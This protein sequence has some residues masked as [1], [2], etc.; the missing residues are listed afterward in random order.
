MDYIDF[1]AELV[2]TLSSMAR[3]GEEVFLRQITKNNGIVYDGITLRVPGSNI[4]P[5]LY[6]GKMK[7]DFDEGKGSISDLAAAAARICRSKAVSSRQ[8][9]NE[10]MDYENFKDRVCFRLVNRERN[11]VR[12]QDMPHHDILD[13]SMIYFFHTESICDLSGTVLIHNFDL[14]R[15]DVKE[16]ELYQDALRNTPILEPPE[17]YRL[18]EYDGFEIRIFTNKKGLYGAG[19]MLYEGV[20]ADYAGKWEQDLF[21]LPSSIHEVLVLPDLG[22]H[23]PEYL[24]SMVT[25][26]NA[27]VVADEEVLSDE[28]YVWRYGSGEIEMA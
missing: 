10:L 11:R 3:E 4:S 14:S 26:V 23:T 7:Q 9:E 12:L 5:T 22:E 17:T 16:E 27:V 20:L 21:V 24:K 2:E 1:R 28:V 19:V 13:L 8:I 6:I 18:V 15:W 25:E